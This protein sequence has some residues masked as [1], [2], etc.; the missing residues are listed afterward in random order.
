M[1]TFS[2]FS[3]RILSEVLSIYSIPLSEHPQAVLKNRMSIIV[4][5]V[6]GDNTK[7]KLQINKKIIPQ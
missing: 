5:K 7:Y 4:R 1:S 2:V 6:K 3:G